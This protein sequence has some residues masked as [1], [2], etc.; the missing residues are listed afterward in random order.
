MRFWTVWA[1]M[2]LASALLGCGGDD[3]DATVPEADRR[4]RLQAAETWMYQ[5]SKLDEGGAID[6][7]AGTNYPLLVLEPGH[8]HRPCTGF[9]PADFG[10]P[11]VD[12]GELCADVYDSQA[13][14]A[15]LR[16]TPAGT[17]RLLI[18][19]IDVGQAEWYR[20]YWVEGWAPPP[21]AANGGG[22]GSPDFILAAD[23]DG[24]AGNFV[25]AYWDDRW[26]ELW[27]G[28]NG[29]DGIIAELVELG[30]DGVYLDW[31]EAYD[32]ERVQAAAGSAVDPAEEMAI[33]VEQIG[34][35]GRAMTPEFLLIAQN[36][37][38][39]IDSFDDPAVV[40]DTIDGLAVED[41][42]YYGDGSS[43][44]WDDGDGD[45]GPYDISERL[46]CEATHCANPPQ[47]PDN[48][49]PEDD[50]LPSG[51]EPNADGDDEWICLRDMPVAGDLHGGARHGCLPEEEETPNCWSTEN[52][53][54]AYESYLAEYVPVFSVD[55]VISE[56]KAAEVY[57]AARAAGLRPI[58]TRVQL[59]QS[60]P[61][62]PSDYD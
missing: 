23:P 9:D 33:F 19:Y 18:A 56:D 4:A 59:S 49:C 17:E 14:L 57:T 3:D 1:P 43:E 45:A 10:A 46:A 42:W 21:T 58:V 44:S 11:G 31:V 28:G 36:A 25:V 7:L 40:A 15:A 54:A 22:P 39:L 47:A 34:E 30:F 41:T 55:Y 26:K 2:V 12:E 60:S 6:V 48:V 29:N 51:F 16:T 35:R 50:Q 8:N 32:D 52:R 13:M 37:T 61:T 24:W 20:D 53:L 27:L 5:I 62:P 38:F